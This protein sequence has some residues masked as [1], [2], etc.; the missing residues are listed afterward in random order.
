MLGPDSLR[1]ATFLDAGSGS[2]LFSLAARRLGAERVHSFDYD[3]DSVGTTSALRERSPQRR[4]LDC[5]AGQRARRGLPGR[6]RHLGRGLQ[7][8]RPASH[9]GHAEGDGQRRASRAAGGLLY[10]AIY[11]D[12][13]FRSR[14]WRWIKRGYN[15]VPPRLRLPY[16]LAVAIPQELLQLVKSTVLLHPHH[17]VQ[18]WTRYK[19]L[20]GMNRWHNIVGLDWR[21]SVRGR[22]PGAGLRL[23]P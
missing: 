15:R 11:N 12:Q 14:L 1:D 2:G 21:L 8:G 5:R 17:Y 10:I 6:S 7:L 20:R 16:L 13:G 19:R 4:A 18:G 9:R 23:L 3:A 22:A